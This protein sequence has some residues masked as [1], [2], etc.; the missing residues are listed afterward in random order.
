MS[1]DTKVT[2]P[3]DYTHR[4]FESIKSDLLQIAQRYYPENF[5]DFSEASFGSLMLD[6]VA[7]VGDQLSFYLDYSVNESFLDTAYSYNNIAR[8]GRIMGYKA[9]GPAS[10]FGQVALYAQVPADTS[11][12]GPD[13][14]YIPLLKRGSR[15]KSQTG[16]DF[17]LTSNIDFNA[18]KNPIIVSQVS[19]ATGSPTFFAIKA[20]GNVV[21]GKFGRI[22]KTVGKFQRFMKIKLGAPSITE[23]ISVIDSQGNEF[24]EVDYLSQ[25]MIYKELANDNYK[26]DNVPSVLKPMVVSRKFVV[27]RE[28][29]GVYLQFGSGKAGETNV[30]AKPQSVALDLFG[31][32]YVTDTTFDPTRLS[33]NSSFGIVPANTTLSI[34]YRVTNAAN[35][36]VAVGALNKI[37]NALVEFAD[38]TALSA[39]TMNSVRESIEVSNETQILGETSLPNN[40]E[41]KRRIYDTFPTQNRAV[42]QSD[43]ES[44]CY[45]MPAKYGSIS[46]V[47]TQKDP[48][49]LKR[50]LNLYVVSEDNFGKLTLTNS[51]IK[52][53]LKTWLNRYRMINDTIDILDPYLINLGINY[54]I[55]V[56]PSANKSAVL[57]VAMRALTS[58]YNEKMF[59]GEHFYISDVYSILK[60]QDGILDVS[61]VQLIT[62]AGARYSNI[63]FAIN[64]NLSPDGS[65]LMCPK[66]AIF[67]VKF[68]NVDIKGKVT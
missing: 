11:G 21:S 54:T 39:L 23:I 48:D 36:N 35:S 66:N 7:Y 44:L 37:G 4:D 67:E 33:K 42:T 52:N 61:N 59:I 29:N 31:K 18:P 27:V 49:S 60:D 22:T 41:L 25:D 5:Q 8:H 68:P 45:R 12:I 47:S 13:N 62:K 32:D 15:F 30:I 43:Y 57:G 24:Y 56:M 53:N 16:L 40:A 50:N 17:I 9:P 28:R 34:V 55:K 51:T 20:Y 64:K 10:T 3:I 1:K 2:M 46:R 26:N 63:D 14:R 58:Q 65:Y 38:S 6:A 19:D